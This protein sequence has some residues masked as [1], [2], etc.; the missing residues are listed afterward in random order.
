MARE[1]SMRATIKPG[2]RQPRPQTSIR[3]DDGEPLPLSI[4]KKLRPSTHV[5]SRV[6]QKT[7]E[8]EKSS[9]VRRP[10]TAMVRE[11]SRSFRKIDY[12]APGKVS[13]PAN[14][15]R[16]RT[17]KLPPPARRS[18][19]FSLLVCSVTPPIQRA[20]HCANK[21]ADLP[22]FYR[23]QRRNPS[24]CFLCITYIALY[25]ALKRKNHSIG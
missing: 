19:L 22:P 1:P 9:P 21:A 10:M 13:D 3:R 5:D 12:R 4:P 16:P 6:G 20:G 25:L 2:I 7:E 15:V 11:E 23:A 24:R 17:A 8:H 18:T 14:Y